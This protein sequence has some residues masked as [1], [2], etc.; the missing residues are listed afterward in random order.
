MHER[1]RGR[2]V[3]LTGFSG[4]G[5]STICQAAECELSRT[6]YQVQ[7]ID[8]DLIRRS[9]CSDLG[10]TLEDRAANVDRISFVANMLADHGII[11]LVAV[12]APL[13]AMRNAAR[14]RI[15]ELLEVFV[16]APLE[17]CERRD[18]KGLYRRARAGL[19][20]DFT[21]IDSPFECPTKPHLICNTDLESVEE[22]MRKVVQLIE[23]SISEPPIDEPSSG[24]RTIA[25]D[26][27]GVIAEYNGWQGRYT[28][29]EPR[30]DVLQALS[31]LHAEGWRIVIHT[32]RAAEDIR[33]YLDQNDV[34]Y[35]EINRNS[36]YSVGGMKPVATVYWDDRALY[37]SGNAL[38]D[39][40]KIRNFW[41]WNKRR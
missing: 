34:V 19:I 14:T 21:G 38:K 10:F 29:G 32:T 7:I 39:L 40:N 4:S 17:I 25:V 30:L 11:V 12:I 5:K 20:L 33:E 37:Y 31:I 24:K 1:I 26:F 36:E 3:W 13:E 22:S 23:T 2:V 27:D 6:G 18:P 8:G 28:L 16:S 41:T 9:L 15:P 35:D